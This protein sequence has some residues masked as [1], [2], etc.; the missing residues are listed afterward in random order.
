MPIIESLIAGKALSVAF[1]TATG[2]LKD[3]MKQDDLG[4]LLVLLY[5]DYGDETHLG[6]DVFYSWRTKEPLGGALKE[7]LDGTRGAE[8]AE[9]D[10]LASMIEPRLVRT[11]DEDRPILAQRLARA[12]VQATPI[13]VGDEATRLLLNRV[14]AGQRRIV[15][16][17]GLPSDGSEA[18]GLAAA[19]VVGPLRHV[20]AVADVEAAERLAEEGEVSAAAD[21]LLAVVERLNLDP[22]V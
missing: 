21:Q 4:R 8:P 15:E 5:A 16:A 11:P 19:L 2:A 14:E 13:V 17:I 10:E 3:F 18:S 12:A 20:D 6:R 9:V 1:D 22:P 7:M